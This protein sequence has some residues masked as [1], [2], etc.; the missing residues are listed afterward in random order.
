MNIYDI[1][2]LFV[3][4]SITVDS[5]CVNKAVMFATVASELPQKRPVDL[6]LD[7]LKQ[8]HLKVLDQTGLQVRT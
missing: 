1:V 8:I 6:D 3:Y 4:Y 5:N 7:L 2:S